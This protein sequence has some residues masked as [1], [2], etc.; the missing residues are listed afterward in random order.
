MLPNRFCFIRN[1]SPHVSGI[2]WCICPGIR[3]ALHYPVPIRKRKISVYLLK[4]RTIRKVMR[5]GDQ[6]FSACRKFFHVHYLCRIF[7]G[8]KVSCGIFFFGEGDRGN[9][10]GKYSTAAILI[11]TLSLSIT[12][13]WMPA[14]NRPQVQKKNSFFHSHSHLAFQS[15]LNSGET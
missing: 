9:W 5:V 11:L 12:T 8:G 1:L 14:W 4:G 3:N 6:T 10:R 7:F 13:I 15:K 2:I